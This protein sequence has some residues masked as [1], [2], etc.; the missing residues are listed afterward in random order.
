MAHILSKLCDVNFADV[1]K[2]LEEHAPHHHKLGMY[3]EHLWHNADNP[4][5]V[6]FLFRVDHLDEAMQRMKRI[7]SETLRDHP[8]AKLPET[9]FLADG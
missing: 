9:T 5:E 7:H 6:L 3:L 4:N 8:D 2:T 1:K